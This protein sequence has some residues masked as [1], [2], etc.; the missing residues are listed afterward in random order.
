MMRKFLIGIA[1][2]ILGVVLFLIYNHYDVQTVGDAIVIDPDVPVLRTPDAR[3]D[4]LTDF[5]FA[6]HYIEIEDPELGTLRVHYLDEG[7]ADGELIVMLHGQAT[8]SYSFRDM[9]PI[10]TAAGFRVIAPDMVGFG[11]SDKPADWRAHTF[12]KDV[13]WLEATLLALNIS[14]ATGFLFD[15]GGYFGL[16]VVVKHPE[17]FSRLVLN[18]TTVPMGNSVIGAAWVAGWRRYILKPEVFPISGMVSDMTER[19]LDADTL[20]G[21][22]APYPDEAYKGG[23]RRMPMM[24]PATLLH[25]AAAP[26]QEVWIQLADWDKPTLTQVSEQIGNAGFNPKEFHDQIP[27]TAGQPHTMYPNAGFFLIEEN[28]EELARAVIEFIEGST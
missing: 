21:L 27:G 6:P 24:I 1:V 19:E 3:F 17:M 15:W 20:K 22:D 8:W 28:P 16:P 7:P 9:I 14:N 13:D 10:L 4:A 2:L 11:R 23:P 18:T 12:Q 25:P 26:N 5:P